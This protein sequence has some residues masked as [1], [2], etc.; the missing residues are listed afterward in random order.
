MQSFFAP[1]LNVPPEL[2]FKYLSPP[3]WIYIGGWAIITLLLCLLARKRGRAARERCF[4]AL[5]FS[6]IVSEISRIVWGVYFGIFTFQDWLPL[7]LC[8]TIIFTGPVMLFTGNERIKHSF[9]AFT[10]GVAMPAAVF[11]L[12]TPDKPVYTP[13]CFE[14]FQTMFSHGAIICAGV[15]LVAV[16]GFRPRLRDLPK[17]FGMLLCWLAVCFAA[18]QVINR[19]DP[20]EAPRSANYMFLTFAPKNTPLEAFESVVGRFYILPVLG[21]LAAVWVVLF[22]PWELY[23]R[24]KL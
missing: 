12:L 19:I 1:N 18:N 9:V 5:I 22:I 17:L 4:A 23:R 20:Q 6:I 10:Y 15:Y 21:L 11:A 2:Q 3:H 16:L 13:F 8:A 7:H 14:F 24:R